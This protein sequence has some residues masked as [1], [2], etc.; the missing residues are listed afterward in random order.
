MHH[1]PGTCTKPCLTYNYDE[2]ANFN[3]R[4]SED[5]LEQ[6]YRNPSSG[7]KL[8]LCVRMDLKMG[9]GKIAAQ[10]SHGTLGTVH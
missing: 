4:F 1:P 3:F 8:V 9:I 2:L 7:Y 6:I 5:I 10:C